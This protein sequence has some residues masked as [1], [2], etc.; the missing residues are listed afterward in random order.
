MIHEGELSIAIRDG[1]FVFADQKGR[2]IPGVPP[3]AANGHDL[4]ELELFLS[5]ADLHIDPSTNSSKWDGTHVDVG[6]M[7]DWML[8]AE[9]PKQPPGARLEH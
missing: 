9:Q 5:E 4:E 6:E 1:K 3:G 8:L 7:L 2:E